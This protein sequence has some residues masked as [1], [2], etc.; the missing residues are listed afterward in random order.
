MPIFAAKLYDRATIL[1]CM[2]DSLPVMETT[3]SK[4]QRLRGLLTFAKEN[5]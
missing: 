1:T 2:L 4:E 3:G 5:V